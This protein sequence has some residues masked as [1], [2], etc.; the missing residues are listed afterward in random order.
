MIG[1]LE[2]FLGHVQINNNKMKFSLGDS[3]LPV[4]AQKGWTKKQFFRSRIGDVTTITIEEAQGPLG[5][6]VFNSYF[7]KIEGKDQY[8]TSIVNTFR[9]LDILDRS[10]GA[11]E[12]SMFETLTRGEEGRREAEKY[13]SSL[14]TLLYPRNIGV[15]RLLS[16]SPGFELNAYKHLQ[17]E[18]HNKM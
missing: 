15:T 8:R 5:L 1:L 14:V 18:I 7:L 10:Q 9:E 11:D 6:T 17:T 3:Q 13:G 12:M 2:S 16:A 4:A